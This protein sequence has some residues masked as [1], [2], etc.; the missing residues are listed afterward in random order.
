MKL[1]FTTI[2]MAVSFCHGAS[3]LLDTNYVY[4]CFKVGDQGLAPSKPTNQKIYSG[5]ICEVLDPMEWKNKQL[6]LSDQMKKVYCVVKYPRAKKA[7]LRSGTSAIGDLSINATTYRARA[8]SI[9][10]SEMGAIEGKP[11]LID[12]LQ[13]VSVK[14]VFNGTG[15]SDTILKDASTID[16]STTPVEDKNT[17]STGVYT[18]GSGGAYSTRQ[19]AYADVAATLTG[20]LTLHQISATTETVGAS[21]GATLATFTFKDS[22]GLKP[23]G[24]P[25]GGYVSTATTSGSSYIVITLTTEGPGTC[26]INGLNLKY[27]DAGFSTSARMMLITAVTIG[28][29]FNVHDCFIDE[30]GETSTGAAFECGDVD[31]ILYLWNNKIVCVTGGGGGSGKGFLAATISTSS[32][33]EN[34]TAIGLLNSNVDPYDA[35][36]KAITFRN[37]AAIKTTNGNCFRNV[38]AATIGYN[39]ASTDA[40]GDDF[41][42]QSGG[43]I[44]MTASNEFQS[45]T[46]SDATFLD[47]KISG[48]GQ[49]DAGGVATAITGNTIG[50]RGNAGGRA[51]STP[52]IGADEFGNYGSSNVGAIVRRIM[53]KSINY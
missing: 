52:T 47:C 10:Y 2:L 42:T 34:N 19:L 28:N 6:V 3:E 29:T 14:S 18:Y 45:L 4:A 11:N 41:F 20:N 44:N 39:N 49:L 35:N 33:I 40:Q 51:G 7:L 31:A 32:I 30:S 9:N 36:G 23:F 48:A 5:M 26:E 16:Y 1:I 53:L 37:N 24:N 8:L 38:A 25:N 43:I 46:Q 21:I 22:S 15:Y 17:I 12:T 13:S 27:G 50:S